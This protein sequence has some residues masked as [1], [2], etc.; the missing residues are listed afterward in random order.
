MPE[1]KERA[2]KWY[3]LLGIP[4]LLLMIG[5]AC[6]RADATVTP[7]STPTLVGTPTL[8]PTREPT[9]PPT[10]TPTPTPAPGSTVTATATPERTPTPIPTATPSTQ[11]EPT[12]P[13]ENA[14]DRE[15]LWAG[16]VDVSGLR[17]FVPWLA[18]RVMPGENPDVNAWRFEKGVAG[19]P[20]QRLEIECVPERVDRGWEL[21]NCI[22]M[23]GQFE[24]TRI[25]VFVPVE[26][27][28]GLKFRIS[29]GSFDVSVSLTRVPEREEPQASA[30]VT[31]LWHESGGGLH[32]DI[33]AAD[34][35]VYAP[36]FDGLIEILD[37]ST[38]RVLSVAS[39]S[40]AAGRGPHIVLD[41]KAS[42]GLLYAATVSNGLVV[43]DVSQPD[44]PRLI[45]QYRRTL[46]EGSPENFTN[47]HNIFL[48]P[49]ASVV[50]A[51]NHLFPEQPV[52]ESAH[53]T[54]LRVID[55]SDPTSPKETGRFF[56]DSDVGFVHDINV[57]E[58]ERQLVAFLNYW[59]AGLWILD[60]TDPSSIDVLGSID[61]DGITSHSGWPFAMD[62]RLYYAHAEEGY[63]RHLTVLDVTDLA[64]PQIISRFKTRPGI[65]IHNV[66]VANGVA[67]IS[68]YID[69]PACCR[70]QR[71]RKPG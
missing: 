41:V 69:G 2:I 3:V 18:L 46:G 44:N 45:G 21:V 38:G 64:N 13:P 7:T 16:E 30:N 48:S 19:L 66:E 62:G 23:K 70:P 51:I 1:S 25:T 54:D 39:L 20:G 34:G 24:G 65:S 5:V 40:G 11:P 14:S 61:W 63:D 55:V 8:A 10:P 56:I 33:W 6:S 29:R 9:R 27:E 43:F 58:L 57:I 17:E 32:T 26:R 49:D 28:T 50:Y 67:Y 53:G 15:G 71:P 59:D 68:Y 60:V 36:R 37:G 22:G 35:L 47:V 12:P 42:G 4:A 52:S 31:A